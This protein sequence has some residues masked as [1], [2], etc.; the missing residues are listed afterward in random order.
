MNNNKYFT[1]TFY[2][3]SNNSVHCIASITDHSVLGKRM[4]DGIYENGCD[5][6]ESCWCKAIPLG[7]ELWG[8]VKPATVNFDDNPNGHLVYGVI[9]GILATLGKLNVTEI[10]QELGEELVNAKDGSTVE[11]EFP[12]G[13]TEVSSDGETLKDLGLSDTMEVIDNK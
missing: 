4:A 3:H 5:L 11:R 12:L 10:L 9:K 6:Y 1:I 8:A 7:H 13:V 2:K